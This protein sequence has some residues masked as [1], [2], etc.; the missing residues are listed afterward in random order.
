MKKKIA[1]KRRNP[2]DATFRN[3]NALKRRVTRLEQ[4]TEAL[5]ND[6]YTLWQKGGRE[7]VIKTGK[8]TYTWRSKK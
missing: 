8:A 6:I 2:Q 4:M 5:V 1:K 7:G 3:I